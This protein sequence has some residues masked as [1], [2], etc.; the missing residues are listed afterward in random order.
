MQKAVIDMLDDDEP[1]MWRT[2]T[3]LTGGQTRWTDSKAHADVDA[4][5]HAHAGGWVHMGASG[6]AHGTA[7]HAD[8]LG[9][10]TW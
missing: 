7:R 9:T 3:A 1:H 10:T 4:H 5:A 2:M 8:V 6:G